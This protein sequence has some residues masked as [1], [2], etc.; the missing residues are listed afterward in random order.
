MRLK[1]SS[2]RNRTPPLLHLSELMSCSESYGENQANT[3]KLDEATKKPELFSDGPRIVTPDCP[4]ISLDVC[5]VF[6][7]DKSLI[8]AVPK[9]RNPGSSGTEGL[10]TPETLTTTA[11]ESHG[12]IALLLLATQYE[13]AF[14]VTD[15][16]P[17]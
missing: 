8:N 10:A 2:T 11:E 9:S 7:N 6:A 4:Q 5:E 17:A 16:P 13:S 12:P 3:L 15:T 1:V 14:L